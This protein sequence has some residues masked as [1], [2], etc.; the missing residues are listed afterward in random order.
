VNIIRYI[1]ESHEELKRW[2]DRT[3]NL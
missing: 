3:K 1:S 2:E